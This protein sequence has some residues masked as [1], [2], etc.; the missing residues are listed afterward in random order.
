MQF[1]PVEKVP[2]VMLW[3][4][5]NSLKGLNLGLHEYS[6]PAVADWSTLSKGEADWWSWALGP[7]DLVKSRKPRKTSD[8]LFLTRQE[9]VSVPGESSNNVSVPAA[10][11]QS[12]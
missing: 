9:S 10:G 2:G 12:D 3:S 4:K 8:L 11:G 1:V 6:S 5:T 7:K